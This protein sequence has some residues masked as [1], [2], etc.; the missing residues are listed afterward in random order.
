MSVSGIGPQWL[1][2][3]S[4]GSWGVCECTPGTGYNSASH[5]STDPQYWALI[6][7]E[8]LHLAHLPKQPA[9]A[10]PPRAWARSQASVWIQ[11][12]G[13]NNYYKEKDNNWNMEIEKLRP[14]WLETVMWNKECK[15][16][17]VNMHD[18]LLLCC[19]YCSCLLLF[20]NSK[21]HNI[22]SNLARKL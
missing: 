22:N 13:N 9:A 4:P 12:T 14:S 2:W 5:W 6:G 3:A 1:T 21:T 16:S 11:E 19:W 17:N 18:V 8:K 15:T 7:Q 10:A 20:Q